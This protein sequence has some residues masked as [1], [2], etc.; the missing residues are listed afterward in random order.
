[1]ESEDLPPPA[2]VT[3]PEIEKKMATRKREIAGRCAFAEIEAA[4][5]RTWKDPER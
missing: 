2:T 3:D 5:E 4:R 1:M